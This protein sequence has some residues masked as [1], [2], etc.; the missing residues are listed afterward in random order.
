[1]GIVPDRIGN[2]VRRFGCLGYETIDF[3]VDAGEGGGGEVT[4]GETF[5]EGA[6]GGS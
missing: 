2:S 3:I 6:D 1:M 5:V 4:G